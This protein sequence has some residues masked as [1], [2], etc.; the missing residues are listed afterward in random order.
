MAMTAGEC[1]PRY[2][3][4][5]RVDRQGA[6]VS[7]DAVHQM[8]PFDV[9]TYMR[10]YN[11]T[12]DA[13]RFRDLRYVD[14]RR[15][16]VD[17]PG[18]GLFKTAVHAWRGRFRHWGGRGFT[19]LDALP[20]TVDMPFARCEEELRY[21]RRVSALGAT[22]LASG[23]PVVPDLELCTFDRPMDL[24]WFAG[25]GARQAQHWLPDLDTEWRLRHRRCETDR[26]FAGW[27]NV[28]NFSIRARDRT[29]LY[30]AV[31]SW[32]SSWEPARALNVPT[33]PVF[34]Y[35]SHYALDPLASEDD[36]ITARS[37][38]LFNIALSEF[39]VSAFL[40]FLMAASEGI[41]CTKGGDPRLSACVVTEG[42]PTVPE[43]SL[44]G[45]GET[46]PTPLA[47]TGCLMPLPRKVCDAISH[48]GVFPIVAGTRFDAGRSLL[49]LERSCEVPWAVVDNCGAFGQNSPFL[50]YDFNSGAVRPVPAAGGL[51]SVAVPTCP[52][53]ARLDDCV[54]EAREYFA[55][56][57]LSRGRA[58]DDDM[59][60]EP[61]PQNDKASCAG[62][63]DA[64]SPGPLSEGAGAPDAEGPVVV[65]LSD[66]SSSNSAVDPVT[67]DVHER[68]LA[69]LRS[70]LADVEAERD[71]AVQESKELIEQRD[72]AQAAVADARKL[73]ET[74][75]VE[76]AMRAAE[77]A[78][79]SNELAEARH[80]LETA[81]AELARIRGVLCDL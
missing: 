79:R 60:V 27:H 80:E 29:Q 67:R 40:R 38:V 25:E 43:P 46:P 68:E 61:G 75:R 65:V 63:K 51:P 77:V 10:R 70:R 31:P 76:L 30:V 13:R 69:G 72:A 5:D 47:S 36:D 74:A 3:D 73:V 17:V 28:E 62:I 24:A 42:P 32:W 81:R 19:L 11:K 14:A 44:F 12:L 57:R 2:V 26:F 8:M 4:D 45:G 56:C 52:R 64:V 7:D 59:E 71:R 9:A 55:E 16:F 23:E 49:A 6:A 37:N 1:V 35:L 20:H 18:I 15:L 54:A 33:P 66:H 58:R 41:I 34:A 21:V 53:R 78:A 48:F 39:V 50:A 22:L